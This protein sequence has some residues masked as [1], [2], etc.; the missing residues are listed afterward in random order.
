M[1]DVATKR[2]VSLK[3]KQ[4][5]IHKTRAGVFPGKIHKSDKDKHKEQKWEQDPDDFD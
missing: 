3:R 2:K 1:N 5:S 4:T